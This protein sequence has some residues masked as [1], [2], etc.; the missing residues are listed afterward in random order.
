MIKKE[1]KNG[2]VTVRQD[3]KEIGM[4]WEEAQERRI[5]REDWHQC[6]A[7][8]VFNTDWAKDK[9][10]DEIFLIF[11][12]KFVLFYLLIDLYIWI[13]GWHI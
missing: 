11:L 3:L 4:F 7:Q 6:V 13:W 2:I 1:R 9:D 10:R 5:D 8:C 12:V